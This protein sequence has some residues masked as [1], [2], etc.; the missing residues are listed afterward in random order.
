MVH[1]LRSL[2]LDSA[3]CYAGVRVDHLAT[4][5]QALRG[6]GHEAPYVYVDVRK[7]VPRWAATDCQADADGAALWIALE[8]ALLRALRL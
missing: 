2:C 1:C 4:E 5:L 3:R 6:A 7:H 8:L